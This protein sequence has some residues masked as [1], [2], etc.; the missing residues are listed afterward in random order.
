MKNTG[1]RHIVS[2]E[3]AGA[4][5]Y[6]NHLLH[7]ASYEYAQNYVAGKRVLDYGCG[8]GYG[9]HMLAMYAENIIAV[10]VSV[11]AVT[12]AKEN[13]VSGNLVF[14]EVKD[15]GC[16]KFDVITSFQVIEHVSNDKW[17]IEKLKGMLNPGGV[18]LLTT[19]DKTNRL[20]NY[21]Q[22]PWNEFHLKEYSYHSMH[23]LL[24]NYFDDFKILKI[25]SNPK[26]A[27][28]EIVRRKKQR[29]I[30]LPCTLF[31]YP[32]FIRV[33]LLRLEAKAFKKISLLWKKSKGQQISEVKQ[34]EASFLRFTSKDI[35]ISQNS[36]YPTDLFVICQMD[37]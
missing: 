19:P 10:D 9:S 8:S 18:L 22:R 4:A 13:F 23:R 35:E 17:Y 29:L 37:H 3:F 26:L 12:Y 16:E 11:E 24:S 33:F 20:F 27:L 1:E 25:T 28:P 15:L 21:I 7:I 2:S 6:Y 30:T 36:E 14:K 34:K 5:D 32:N 31:F